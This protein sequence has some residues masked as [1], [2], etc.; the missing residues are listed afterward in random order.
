[1]LI[2]LLILLHP[3]KGKIKMTD[4]PVLVDAS[5]WIDYLRSGCSKESEMLDQMLSSG[6][7]VTCDPVRTEIVS[8]ASTKTAFEKLRVLVGSVSNLSASEDIWEKIAEYRFLL[9]R[10]GVQ[11]SLIDLWIVAV[12]KEHSVPIWTLDKDF[13]FMREVLLFEIFQPKFS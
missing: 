1:M 10:R 13:Y 7:V 5:V 4:R 11:A 12:A 9:A 8:G 6:L 3:E 2:S